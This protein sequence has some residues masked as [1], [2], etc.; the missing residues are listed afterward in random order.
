MNELLRQLALLIALVRRIALLSLAI[1]CVVFAMAMCREARAADAPTDPPGWRYTETIDGD[2][3]AFAVKALPAPLA[4]VLVRL[5][6]VNTPERRR[7]KCEWERRAGEAATAI[8][9]TG[10]KWGKYG[11][12]VLARAPVDGADLAE[13]IVRAGHG[14]T[15][16]GGRRARGA[17]A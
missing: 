17:A 13:A 7:P 6:G 12:R 2:T 11:G 10:L 16:D 9:L 15:Y 5:R 8:V 14:R 4:R 3:L 1:M